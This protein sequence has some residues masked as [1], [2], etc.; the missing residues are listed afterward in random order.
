M[1]RRGIIAAGLTGPV[2][3]FPSAASITDRDGMSVETKTTTNFLNY[4]STCHSRLQ[5]EN[6]LF[7]SFFKNLLCVLL[8]RASAHPIL[9]VH[10]HCVIWRGVWRSGWRLGCLVR[11]CA[12]WSAGSRARTA[13]RRPA[14]QGS[15]SQENRRQCQSDCQTHK[16]LNVP[17]EAPPPKGREAESEISNGINRAG[18]NRRRF[19]L[20][21]PRRS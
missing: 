9:G 14:P 1:S 19:H 6:H 11:H 15:Q 13:R 10:L 3:S 17:E 20:E 7:F 8:Y 16:V 12:R 21:R 18:S 5:E 2:A 4:L